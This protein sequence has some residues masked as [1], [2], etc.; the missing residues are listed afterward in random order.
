[1]RLLEESKL[2]SSI[3]LPAFGPVD[4][5]TK[6][7][8]DRHKRSPFP[9][10]EEIKATGKP[11]RT[12]ML[13]MFHNENSATAQERAHLPENYYATADAMGVDRTPVHKNYIERVAA[14]EA[15]ELKDIPYDDLVGIAL[16][17]LTVRCTSLPYLLTCYIRRSEI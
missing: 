10:P 7:D 11:P 15:F 8:I 3:V 9:T 14:V 16:K 1:M 12:A 17:R 6:L 2:Q 13:P 4:E 5:V